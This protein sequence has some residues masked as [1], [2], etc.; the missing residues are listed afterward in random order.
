M[1]DGL[2]FR[3]VSI[4]P[5]LLPLAAAAGGG[6][7][8]GVQATQLVAAGFTLLQRSAP[9]VRALAGRRAAILLPPSAEYLT[10]LAACD[11]RGAVLINPAAARAEIV[12]QLAD[13]GVGAVF[14]NGA[15]ASRL[16][17]DVPRVLLDDGVR[18]ARVMVG[19]HEKTVD[20]GSHSGLLIETES[21]APGR[22][23][24]CAIVYTSAMAGTALGAR[25]THRNLIANAR[26]TV[27]GTETNAGTHCLA[28]LP[29]AHLFGLTVTLLN[30]LLTGGRVTTMARFNPIAAAD[31]MENGGITLF[32]GV[33]A[34]Y[35]AMLAAI[36]RRGGKLSSPTLRVC[37]CGGAVLPVELQ[38][39]WFEATG[40]ELRQGYGLT[41]ASPVVLFNDMSLP[42]RRGTLG[43]PLR[44]VEVTIRDPQ[45]NAE[46]PDETP[47]E[48]CARGET[49]F[50]GYV[51]NGSDGLQV[52][53]GWLA[54]GDR[55]V[56]HADGTISFRGLIKE[57]F[58]RNGFNVYPKEVERAIGALPGVRAVRVFA[59]PADGRES[60][61]GA[62]IEGTVTE[63]EVKRWCESRLASY[64]LP[65]VIQLSA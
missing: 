17:T 10:A 42:N 31:L 54:S 16:P 23:E 58:T 53:D 59:V 63:D 4:S 41:E 36:A 34:V 1:A 30:P 37:L 15:L 57:M 26:Q 52:R 9:L 46:L 20:L 51:R 22:D 12:H 11:G 55:G 35:A 2:T 29:F 60:D 7:V 50:G 6:S 14:T 38:E 39:Q 33:P 49:V 44:D 19:E 32:T 56:R 65:T 5:T 8:D 18:T 45:T 64:K 40:L 61:V 43:V 13:A 62:A 24:E 25:L 47:G 48:I 28:V 21:G 3:V 27:L